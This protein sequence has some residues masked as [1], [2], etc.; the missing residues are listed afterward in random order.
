[1]GRCLMMIVLAFALAGCQTTLT[2]GGERVMVVGDSRAVGPRTLVGTYNG[3]MGTIFSEN[4]HPQLRNWGASIGADLIVL[5][6]QV[7]D[8]V[9]FYTAEGYR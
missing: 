4:L 8:N 3:R 5:H 9:I 7:S 6:Q 1:M 2:P